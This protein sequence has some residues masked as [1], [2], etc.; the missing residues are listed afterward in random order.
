MTIMTLNA[1]FNHLLASDTPSG[2]ERFG[3]NE[4]L[5]SCLEFIEIVPQI[6]NIDNVIFKKGS[7]SEDAKRIMIS[8]HYDE[9]A[10]IVTNVTDNG[11]LHIVKLG[12]SDNKTTEGS[13]VNVITDKIDEN[14]YVGEHVRIPGVIGK[15]AIHVESS[16]DRKKTDDPE[17][18]LVNI[19]YTSK[20]KVTELGIHPGSPV[21]FYKKFDTK[22]G[23]NELFVVG[24]ALD[25]KIGIWCVTKAFLDIDEE[26]LKEKNICL[27]LVWCSQ[28]EVG[29][30]GARAVASEI[31][32][33]VSIDVDV[34]HDN[35]IYKG[36]K[37]ASHVE[38]GKGVVIEYS[39]AS[40]YNLAQ[41]LREVANR[42]ALP[43]QE[44][45]E[46]LGGNDCAAIQLSSKN[47]LTAHLGIPN[48]NM[49]T[50]V[51]MCHWDDINSCI[52]LIVKY[53]EEIE[54]L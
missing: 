11:M 49:H 42:W 4:A 16:E 52:D 38:L 27:Y 29:L 53:I 36:A 39:C 35:K 13:W 17:E 22:F 1:F 7:S 20:E 14:S 32:P 19:G 45:A 51:E 18:F 31:N 46:K 6:D 8:A 5:A 41:A 25:D 40:R 34:T 9:N 23:E 43:Y 33:N 47:C 48:A 44:A 2:F 26:K 15:K 10:F 37:N 3:H 54:Q 50:Q 28:E 21:V 12:G 30:R 24:N